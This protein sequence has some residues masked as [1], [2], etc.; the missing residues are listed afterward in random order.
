[1]K[2]KS[3]KRQDGTLE[4]DVICE[5]CEKPVSITNEFGTFC[6]NRCGENESKDLFSTLKEICDS[7][8]AD[9]EK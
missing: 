5:E 4:V 9:F 8:A 1:M 7:F 6:E 2:I 3:T